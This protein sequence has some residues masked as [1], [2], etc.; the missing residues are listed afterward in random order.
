MHEGAC[1]AHACGPCPLQPV[2]AEGLRVSTFPCLLK[3]PLGGM[4][5]QGITDQDGQQ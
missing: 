5:D 2:C 3:E 1:A 4:A